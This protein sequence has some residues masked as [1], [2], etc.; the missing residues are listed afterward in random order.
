M[1]CFF[2]CFRLGR[3]GSAADRHLPPSDNASPSPC[4]SGANEPVAS[5]NR[6]PLSSLFISEENEEQSSLQTM[7]VEKLGCPTPVLELDVNE[8]KDQAKFL[9]ACGTLPE[10]PIEIRKLSI[11]G[12]N[13]C[14]VDLSPHK[15]ELDQPLK[16]GS[17]LPDTPVEN[18]DLELQPNNSPKPTKVCDE[19]VKGSGSSLH[20]PS[21]CMTY[22]EESNS[23]SISSSPPPT[24][25]SVTACRQRHVHF[26]C[27]SDRKPTEVTSRNT[28]PSPYPT[29]MKLTDEMQTPGTVF[30]THLPNGKN[31]RI[32]S[33]YVYA[34]LNPIENVSQ[35]KKVTDE[36]DFVSIQD[37]NSKSSLSEVNLTP[38]TG[39]TET[40]ENNVNV[41]ASLSSWLKPPFNQQTGAHSGIPQGDRPILGM[42][43]AHWTESEVTH[44]SPKWWDGNGIPNSTHKYKEDQ[45][46]SW[47]ATPFEE[48]L[49]KAL[50]EETLVSQRK[51]ASG[52]P[53]SCKESE[54]SDTAISQF[55]SKSQP[56]ANA[57]SL[58]NALGS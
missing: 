12:N 10:T 11:K 58:A 46:V 55:C 36:E 26:D 19:W 1:G 27:Q 57:L 28:K 53:I 40:T 44:V 42:V 47:H 13:K 30:S 20:T 4:V 50:S 31:P 23:I 33:Q 24:V 21:S 43:A 14:R 52:S 18:Q 16:F 17:W 7:G 6:S 48:R 22:E 34:V 8:L 2:G 15:A 3:F 38:K 29:P 56:D 54:E 25:P 45:K 5:R 9:K 41:E 32:R 49:E 51:M 35:L 37:S 39:L